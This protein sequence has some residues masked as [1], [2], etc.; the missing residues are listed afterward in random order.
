MGVHEDYIYSDPN[1]A[2]AKPTNEGYEQEGQ[3]AWRAY[4]AEVGGTAYNGEPLPTWE[5][6]G[7]RQRNGWRA[8]AKAILPSKEADDISDLTG[9]TDP[10]K[11]ES[12]EGEAAVVKKSKSKANVG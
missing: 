4:A 7:E 8:A 12:P 6:L 5:Q 9:E 3:D 11:T 1:P 2:A 10:E